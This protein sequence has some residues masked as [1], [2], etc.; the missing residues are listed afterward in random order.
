MITLVTV[1]LCNPLNLLRCRN[2][3]SLVNL[4]KLLHLLSARLRSNNS[5]KR[6]HEVRDSEAPSNTADGRKRANCED[7]KMSRQPAQLL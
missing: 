7:W 6:M 4:L 2:L 1:L 3:V 5:M